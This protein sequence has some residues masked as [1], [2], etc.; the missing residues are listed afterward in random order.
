MEPLILFSIARAVL[1]IVVVFLVCV[2]VHEFGHFIVAKRCGVA[3]PAF[4]VGFGPK[5]WKW[6]RG[7]T[8]FSIR[9]LP[10]GG[11]VQ[12]A[13]EIPQDS[14]FKKGE[15]IAV[16]FDAEQR[17]TMLGDPT[18]I[19]RGM[20]GRLVDLDLSRNM[21]MTLDF[22]QGSQ[23]YPVV[24]R[25]K[26]VTGA[27]SS[28][29]LVERHEQVL[30]KPL[31]QRAAMILAGPVMNFI[32]A[33]ILFAFYFMQVGV[34]TNAPVIG[35]IEAGS[36]AS[37]AGL[38]S[39]DRIVAINGN[40]IHRWTDLVRVIEADKTVP[41]K[42][43]T[44]AVA[45]DSVQRQIEVT[46][47]LKKAGPQLGIEASLDHNP[48]LALRTGYSTVYYTSV[49]AVQLYGQIIRH[50]DISNLSGPVGIADVISTQ[51][52]QGVLHVVM[53]AGLLSLNLGL[54]NLLPF[55][56]LDGGRLLFMVVEMV[57]GRAV[58][59]RKE[60]FVHFVGFALLMLFAVV[61]TYRDVTRLF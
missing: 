54:F 36:P 3:V 39:G 6:V 28:I 46:P 5:L 4:A 14:L 33:G 44:V 25:A 42:P 57:R 50:H 1:A 35:G 51:A 7:G 52:Q 61:I 17:I 31:W 21:S 26:L 37:V 49:N 38:Q 27:R 16:Q 23:T 2:V 8:E 22:G 9:L 48:V 43:L 55:P 20:V 30:G 40:P 19:P 13:G 56:A 11:M 24:S 18:D 34:F 10:L 53:I 45:R 47:K 60:S 59:P 29:S 15:Q 32:L 58:D 12:L 41:P